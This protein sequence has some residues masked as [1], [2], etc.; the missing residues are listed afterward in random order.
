M[1]LPPVMVNPSRTESGP[2]QVSKV[3]VDPFTGSEG[4]LP[5]S[6][7]RSTTPGSAG[8]GNRNEEGSSTM[9]EK[10]YRVEAQRKRER[11]DKV[12]SSVFAVIKIT[13]ILAVSSD[14]F[15]RR[16]TS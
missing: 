11:S 8:S 16:Q 3:T 6:I 10:R 9:S 2:S 14:A 5:L 12:S 15:K 7:V 4:V 13:G 1:P